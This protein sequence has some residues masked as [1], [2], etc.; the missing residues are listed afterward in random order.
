MKSQFVPIGVWRTVGAPTL[1]GP[2]GSGELVLAVRAVS[3]GLAEGGGWQCVLVACDAIASDAV[4][5][6]DIGADVRGAV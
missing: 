6:V 3:D 1:R 5:A 2:R 4:R